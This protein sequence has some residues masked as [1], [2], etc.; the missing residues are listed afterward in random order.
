MNSKRQIAENENSFL[1]LFAQGRSGWQVINWGFTA[2]HKLF[3]SST[4]PLRA[5]HFLRLKAQLRHP[6]RAHSAGWI[7]YCLEQQEESCNQSC[8]KQKK[9]KQ[10]SLVSLIWLIPWAFNTSFTS[11]FIHALTFAY[12]PT[13]IPMYHHISR[14]WTPTSIQARQPPLGCRLKGLA[15]NH[16]S[17]WHQRTWH[18][19]KS[20]F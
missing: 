12:L 3:S 16:C 19:T 11:A 17:C 4:A 2:H 6:P 5:G 7:K 15:V 13:C 9:K 18:S 14:I 20:A 1:P 8:K 10:S